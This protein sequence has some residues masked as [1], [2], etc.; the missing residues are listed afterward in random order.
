MTSQDRGRDFTMFI[1]LA[2]V[3]S[4]STGL[5]RARVAAC[6]SLVSLTSRRARQAGMKSFSLQVD[7]ACCLCINL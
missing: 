4:Y 5:P 6:R 3:C 2:L 7:S 1:A